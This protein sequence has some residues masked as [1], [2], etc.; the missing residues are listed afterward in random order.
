MSLSSD[1][2]FERVLLI[3]NIKKAFSD[4][5]R[6]TEQNIQVSANMLDAIDMAAKNNFTTI[7]V[8]I[9][10]MSSRLNSA[11]KA[12]KDVASGSKIILLVQMH[13]E[14][15][16]I[17]LIE[18]GTNG[19]RIADDYLICPLQTSRFYKSLIP[20]KPVQGA[21]EGT[22]KVTEPTEAVA[23]DPKMK[24]KIKE[25]EKLATTDEL[26]GLK[27]RRYIWEFTRQIIKRAKG[28]ND[29]VTLL[30]FDI[31]NFKHYN[32]VYGHAAGDEILKQTAVLIRHCCRPHDVVGRIGGDEFVVIFCDDPKSK[33]DDLEKERRSAIAEHPKETIFIAKRFMSELEKT[34]FPMLGAEGKGVLTISGGLSSFPRDGSTIQQLIGQA[35][36]ALLDAKRSGKNRIYL[37]G[38]PENN[39]ENIG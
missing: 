11:L 28:K 37:V 1:T 16:A 26:T 34:E 15:A 39:I 18:S 14:P 33:P 23:V 20:G 22:V 17:Q 38:A 24:M 7:A 3:G 10:E 2:N 6:L 36:K 4:T 35:D 32:D 8:V 25:L 5:D 12:L 30:M 27:N 31:D 29:R 13:E 21:I 9:S 19:S